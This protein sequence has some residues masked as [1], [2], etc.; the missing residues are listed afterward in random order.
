M[1][2]PRETAVAVLNLDDGRS[3][4]QR[5]VAG[6]ALF[7]I[8]DLGSAAVESAEA[9]SASGEVIVHEDFLEQW[10]SLRTGEQS[11]IATASLPYLG[12]DLAGWEFWRASESQSFCDQPDPMPGLARQTTFTLGVVAPED[13]P[14]FLGVSSVNVNVQPASRCSFQDIP[15]QASDLGPPADPPFVVDHGITTVMGHEA[16]IVEEQGVFSVL[17]LLDDQGSTASM[18]VFPRD[19]TLTVAQVIAIA[20]GIVELTEEEWALLIAATPETPPV[21]TP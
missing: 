10:E 7:V 18:L 4:V 14:L 13:H 15:T 16:R 19:T 6:V 2:L 21:T 9:R 12:L 1:W 17:W 11:P 8:S 5:P 20:G 3:F